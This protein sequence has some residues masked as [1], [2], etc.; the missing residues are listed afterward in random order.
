M[1][2]SIAEAA[3]SDHDLLD[4]VTQVW[5]TY[6]GHDAPDPLPAVPP[7]STSWTISSVVGITGAWQGHLRIDC[8]PGAAAGI[9]DLVLD[10]PASERRDNDLADAV[11][12]LAAIVTSHITALLPA[13]TI[14][15]L[16]V[17]TTGGMERLRLPGCHDT[18]NVLVA[19]KHETV[20]IRL[21][22][23]EPHDNKIVHLPAR[24]APR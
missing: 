10:H 20:Q 5:R 3:L 4:V 16:P 7:P 21:L 14:L 12:R 6:L 22:Q 2:T 19:W 15:C 13:P 1:G 23:A 17:V 11:G 18:N 24:P 9:A 8:G